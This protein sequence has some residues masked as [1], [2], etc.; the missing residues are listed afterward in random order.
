MNPSFEKWPVMKDP[1]PSPEARTVYGPVRRLNAHLEPHQL[2]GS[3]GP[4]EEYRAAQRRVDAEYRK[5]AKGM[6]ALRNAANGVI[7]KY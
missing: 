4:S 5:Y 6:L 1:T 2:Q 7:S 3:P